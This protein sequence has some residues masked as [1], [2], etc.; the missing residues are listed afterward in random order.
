MLIFTLRTV[1]NG[2]LN[3]PAK[4][5]LSQLNGCGVIKKFNI[6]NVAAVRHLGFVVRTRGTTRDVFFVVFN[7]VQIGSVVLIISK[8]NDFC[9][10]AGNCLFMPLLER[11]LGDW[12]P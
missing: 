6:S 11:F 10:L 3:V 1:C 5:R 12:T 8:F 4:L 9:D 7:L 2:N